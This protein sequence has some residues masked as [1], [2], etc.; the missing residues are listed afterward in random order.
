LTIER[1]ESGQ[2][3]WFPDLPYAK[4]EQIIKRYDIEPNEIAMDAARVYQ[5]RLFPDVHGS[6]EFRIEGGNMYTE[7]WIL[8]TFSRFLLPGKSAEAMGNALQFMDENEIIYIDSEYYYLSS[9][10]KTQERLMDVMIRG[11]VANAARELHDDE[12]I[13]PLKRRSGT[14]IPAPDVYPMPE[15]F[16]EACS[17]QQC[18][19]HLMNT[20]PI[21]VLSGKA[22]SG[23][24]LAVHAWLRETRAS[25][26]LV[27]SFTNKIVSDW[28]TK[29][30]TQNVYTMHKAIILLRR[31]ELC[32]TYNLDKIRV[33]IIEE[34]SMAD[35]ELV[36]T[37]LQWVYRRNQHTLHRVVFVG[38]T[39][40]L[41]SIRY[42]N[43][44]SD[45][46]SAFPWSTL[47][48]E[49]NHRLRDMASAPIFVNANRIRERRGDLVYTESFSFLKSTGVLEQDVRMALA[50]ATRDGYKEKDIQILSFNRGA[51]GEGT[52]NKTAKLFFQPTGQ[53]KLDS[54][55]TFHKGDRVMCMRNFYDQGLYTGSSMVIRDIFSGSISTR[56]SKDSPRAWCEV[57]FRSGH[58]TRQPMTSAFIRQSG[59]R[60]GQRILLLVESFPSTSRSRVRLIDTVSIPLDALKLA[61]ACTTH[62]FQGGEIRC[63]IYILT[64]HSYFARW[65]H[66]YTSITRSSHQ[67]Y[68]VDES[69]EKFKE[70]I[71]KPHTDRKSRMALE[72]RNAW[73]SLFSQSATKEILSPVKNEELSLVATTIHETCVI[74]LQNPPEIVLMRCGHN[75]LCGQCAL[76]LMERNKSCPVCRAPIDLMRPTTHTE[77]NKTYI[78]PIPQRVHD[79]TDVIEQAY[80]PL[81][82][83]GDIRIK[84][85]WPKTALCRENAD[86]R[87]QEEFIR[88]ALKEMNL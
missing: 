17:E 15:W 49:H 69:E 74:C 9:V 13:A 31:W 30:M 20:Q 45:I 7:D 63:I 72:L 65:R 83:F 73:A 5:G 29:V 36:E 53:P 26:V 47:S 35:V 4:L 25:E 11:V 52:M 84:W 27:V 34:A 12:E 3:S 64:P 88:S 85:E 2:R 81:A 38:D 62:K 41:E 54:P 23:K 59:K 8:K 68:I 43:V 44:L 39:C 70:R 40:Q 6:N 79:D 61:R 67:V 55:G 21:V 24:T 87:R 56:G 66:I 78:P 16:E 75:V 76:K 1:P 86:K 33:L 80:D 60:S 50:R 14:K 22:G 37:L 19:I 48:F 51:R 10:W 18:A 42:G 71:E 82:V 57:K 77:Y 58:L 32:E 28:R 46:A